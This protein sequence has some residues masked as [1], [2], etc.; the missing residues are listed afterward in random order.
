LLD[1]GLQLGHVGDFLVFDAVM[2]HIPGHILHVKAHIWCC[3]E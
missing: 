2:E 1:T 3:L